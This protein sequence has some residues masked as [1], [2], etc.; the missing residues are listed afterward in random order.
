MVDPLYSGIVRIKERKSLTM[1][2]GT[3]ITSTGPGQGN[4]PIIENELIKDLLQQLQQAS[5]WEWKVVR[6]TEEITDPNGFIEHRRLPIT[7]FSITLY[8]K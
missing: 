2:N 4:R 5:L 7:K 8:H 6:P 3:L 1:S